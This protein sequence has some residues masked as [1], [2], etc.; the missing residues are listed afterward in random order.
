MS[1]ASFPHSPASRTF[2]DTTGYRR[3]GLPVSRAS[4]SAS[5]ARG[6][7][8]AQSRRRADGRFHRK[9][10]D[11]GG[12]HRA[13]EPPDA[14]SVIFQFATEFAICDVNAGGRPE[15]RLKT[16]INGIWTIHNT[17]KN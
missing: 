2:R 4:R 3:N 17:S 11:R 9:S 5:V 14:G 16:L 8:I 15:P 6:Q 7:V 12:D 13:P 1:P 10:P